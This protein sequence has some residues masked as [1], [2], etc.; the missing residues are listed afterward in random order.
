EP[1]AAP[2]SLRGFFGSVPPL[3]TLA[4]LGLSALAPFFLSSAILVLTPGPLF[5]DPPSTLVPRGPC[6]ACGRVAVVYFSGL[7]S[8]S[9]LTFDT[10]S[11]FLPSPRIP[12]RVPRCD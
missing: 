3:S 7:G 11:R 8:G 5:R 1:A 12:T 10:R 9:P 4:T 6:P 2:E